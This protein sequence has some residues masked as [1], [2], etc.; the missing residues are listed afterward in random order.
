MCNPRDEF[1]RE[2]EPILLGVYRA[3]L[4]L[5]YGRVGDDVDPPD[6]MTTEQWSDF[7]QRLGR[8]LGSYDAYRFVFDPYDLESEP[9]GGRLSDDL[10]DIYRD[11]CEG[12]DLHDSG[13]TDEAFWQWRFGFDSHWGRHAAHSLYAL[14]AIRIGE[15]R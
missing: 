5:D 12:L 3:G 10:A 2:L 11:L 15:V 6:R 7:F 4:G 8:H 1:V 13:H 14:Y 9:V